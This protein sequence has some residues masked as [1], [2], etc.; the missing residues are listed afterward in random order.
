[1]FLSSLRPFGV[2]GLRPPC[3]IR[4][5]EQVPKHQPLPPLEK[6][7]GIIIQCAASSLADGSRGWGL[8]VSRNPYPCLSRPVRCGFFKVHPLG[9]LTA[10]SSFPHFTLSYPGLGYHTSAWDYFTP[11]SAHPLRASCGP[12]SQDCSRPHRVGSACSRHRLP[13]A[14]RVQGSA[15]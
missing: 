10:P 3:R 15:S 6:G 14:T 1:M 12:S 7:K 5:G 13:C 4:Q 2:E 11:Q 8:R 9:G